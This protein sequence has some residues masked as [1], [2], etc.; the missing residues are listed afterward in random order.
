MAQ[1]IDPFQVLQFTCCVKYQSRSLELAGPYE[2]YSSDDSFG[3]LRNSF[4]F[5]SRFTMGDLNSMSP[6]MYNNLEPLNSGG[7]EPVCCTV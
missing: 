4:G 1:Q 7:G 3:L 6:L 5:L 2:Q